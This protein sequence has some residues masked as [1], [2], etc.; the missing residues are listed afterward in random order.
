MA[1]CTFLSSTK[2]ISAD[3][4]YADLCYYFRMHSTHN[5]TYGYAKG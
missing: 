1:F 4:D 2:K 5:T 3:G